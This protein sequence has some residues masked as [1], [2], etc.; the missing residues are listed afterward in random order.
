[1][2]HVSRQDKIAV[3]AHDEA[4]E[5]ELI[6]LNPRKLTG[7]QRDKVRY[8]K[9]RYQ[10]VL[11]KYNDAAL[12]WSQTVE[13]LSAANFDLNDIITDDEVTDLLE[14]RTNFLVAEQAKRKAYDERFELNQAKRKSRKTK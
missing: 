12:R 13:G 9:N 10:Q 11:D 5:P 6:D 7:V 3:N 2:N 14:W 8:E 4:D 1:M